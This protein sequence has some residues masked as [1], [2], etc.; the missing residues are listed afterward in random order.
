MRSKMK[1]FFAIIGLIF[2]VN[3][4]LAM[5]VKECEIIHYCIHGSVS[6]KGKE[7]LCH[8]LYDPEG[9]V[10]GVNCGG[11]NHFC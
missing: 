3:I 1:Y 6:C 8:Y 11:N 5:E 4:V 9:N 2:T 7:P 10:M